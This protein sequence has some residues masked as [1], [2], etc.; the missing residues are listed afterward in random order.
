ME[1]HAM[2]HVATCPKCGRE[3]LL[4]DA[5]EHSASLQC[6]EC[7]AFFQ[8]QDV[9]AREIPLAILVGGDDPAAPNHGTV[10]S[11]ETDAEPTGRRALLTI[12]DASFPTVFDV[13]TPLCDVERNGACGATAAANLN[14]TASGNGFVVAAEAKQDVSVDVG[15]PEDTAD[16]IDKWFRAEKV[17]METLCT[18]DDHY[19]PVVS[20]SDNIQASGD[21]A[22]TATMDDSSSSDAVGEIEGEIILEPVDALTD[23]G[24]TWDG[25]EHMERFRSDMDQPPVENH[26][27]PSKSH[28]TTADRRHRQ[29]LSVSPHSIDPPLVF[30]P[31]GGLPRRRRSTIRILVAS[32]IGGVVGLA[33]GYYVLLWIAGPSGD[34]LRVAQHLPAAILPADLKLA[35]AMHSDTGEL[36]EIQAGYVAAADLDDVPSSL[37]KTSNI[38]AADARATETDEPQQFEVPDA[39]V[40]PDV[41][42]AA[43]GHL[44]NPP[45][46]TADELAV[47]L[48]T[49]QQ[50]QPKLVSGDLSDG[51]EVQRAKGLSYSLL[52]ELAQ[53]MS[54][55]D[56]ASRADYIKQL[57]REAH[58]LFQQ[59]LADAH[60]RDE[61]ALIARKWI[62]SRHRKH[63]G[64]FFAGRLISEVDKGSVVECQFDVGGREALIVVVPQDSTDQLAQRSRSLGIV[65]WIVDKPAEGVSGYTGEAKQ[66]VW[67]SRLIP[68]E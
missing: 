35:L 16:R 59:T 60:T 1:A 8:I 25:G 22:E 67:A 14:S 33:L 56:A 27:R 46:F 66:A 26:A 18:V 21:R 45:S 9:A 52:C 12:S 42:V 3:L 2:A 36:T 13:D 29:Y 62:E 58:A 51:L 55:V 4:T 39:K 32:V 49:A 6:P 48:E 41:R 61:V 31:P 53:K 24:A 5:T 37:D 54:F 63:G 64:V 7:H 65:G 20:A 23:D 11:A 38:I 40:L 57:A 15:P 17:R 34:F 19:E 47:A 68:L 28:R 30:V 50:A 43:V 44:L 10:P